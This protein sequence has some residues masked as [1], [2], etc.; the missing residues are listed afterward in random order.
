[1]GGKWKTIILI[2]L[3]MNRKDR[4]C[5][6]EIRRDIHGISA[7]MLSKELRDL[8]MNLLV[9]RTVHDTKPVTV[10]YA[11]TEHGKTSILVV[12]AL[13]RWGVEH[14]KVIKSKRSNEPVK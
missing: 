9:K 7:N 6:M 3:S 2:Y 1:M 4:N 10:E 13:I 11:I 14:R 8:E 12:E 5:F